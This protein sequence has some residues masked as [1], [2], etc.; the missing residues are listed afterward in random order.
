MDMVKLIEEQLGKKAKIKYEPLQQGDVVESC[1]DI[2][3]STKMIGFKPKI[4][5]SIGKNKV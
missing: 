2:N 4:S 1:A 5:I 3:Y